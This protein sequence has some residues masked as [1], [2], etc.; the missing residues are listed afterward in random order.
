MR[1]VFTELPRADC[2]EAIEQLLAIPTSDED[3]AD[4]S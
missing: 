1:T 2:V 3:L 4:V